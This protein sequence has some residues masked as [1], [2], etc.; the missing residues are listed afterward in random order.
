MATFGTLSTRLT[1]SLKNLRGKGKLSPADVDGTLREI[2]RAMLDADVSL[3]VVKKFTNDVRERALSDEVNKA[4]N[5]AQQVVQIV[6]EELVTILGGAQRRLEFAKKPPTIIM[7][8]GLQGAGKTTLAGKLAKY[9]AKEKHTPLLVACDLQRPNAVQQLEVVG[10]NAGVAVYSPEPGNGVGDPVKVAKDSIKF[11]NDKQYDVVIIDTAGRLGVDAELMKQAADI[12]KATSPDEVLFVIDAM[13]GQDAVAT[14]QAFQEGVD[15]TGVVLTKLDGD[16][17][18][19]AALSVVSETERPIMFASTGENLDDFEPFY[20]DRMAS[21]ILD[22]GDILTLIEQAQEAFDEKE[23]AQLQEKF[24]T[25]SFTLEDFLKQMQQLKNMGSMK[26]MLGMLPGAGAMKEQLDNFDERELVRTEAII[27]SM[28]KAERQNTKLLNGSR[29]LRIA[30]GSGMTV[31]DVNTLV[32]RFEQAAKMMK[33]VAK[34]GMPQIPGMGPMGAIGHGGKKQQAKKKGSKSG[35]P[36]K[37]AAENAALAAGGVKP[38]NGG[39][40]GLGNSAKTG[41]PTPEEL[42]ALQKMLGKG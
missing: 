31:T 3:N 21:R 22:L 7:L 28:T 12:R 35:N 30:K 23:A 13:I 16:A 32:N 9:L 27:Q 40:F 26:K 24:A 1:E 17:R 15:F 14:A 25:D 20:P 19:G 38:G 29:R 41:G 5:P 37:R 39:G 36:A 8:A 34:G 18:G 2:R 6:N 11:A 4:L 42:E 33:T 10:K